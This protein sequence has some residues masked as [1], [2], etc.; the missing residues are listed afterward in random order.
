M[1]TVPSGTSGVNVWLQSAEKS[2]VSNVE[3]K[4]IG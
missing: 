1:R 4:V 3:A 2:N